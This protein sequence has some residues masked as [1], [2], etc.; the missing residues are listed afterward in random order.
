MISLLIKMYGKPIQNIVTDMKSH[1]QS[2]RFK[3][4]KEEI[5]SDYDRDVKDAHESY[6][7]SIEAANK[8]LER[9]LNS[10][11]RV[12]ESRTQKLEKLLQNYGSQK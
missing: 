10:S 9:A 11:E 2:W 4:E 8:E 1:D 12:R 3:A 6:Q 7:R 5:S